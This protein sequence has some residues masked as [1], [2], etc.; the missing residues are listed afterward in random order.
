MFVKLS[1]HAALVAMHAAL[2]LAR[3]EKRIVLEQSGS[4]IWLRILV[5][6][7]GVSG[8]AAAFHSLKSCTTNGIESI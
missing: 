3:A 2:R 5:C 7:T 8:A 4:Q 6:V 1:T